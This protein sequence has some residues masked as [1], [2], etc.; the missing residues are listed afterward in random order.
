LDVTPENCAPGTT[1]LIPSSTVPPS[2][3]LAACAWTN[4]AGA[5]TP[6]NAAMGHV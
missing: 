6:M 3:A 5:S 2:V 4:D 1:A